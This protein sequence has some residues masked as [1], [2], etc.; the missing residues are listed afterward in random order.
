MVTA[1]YLDLLVPVTFD[2]SCSFLILIILYSWLLILFILHLLN[3][4]CHYN[5]HGLR[6]EVSGVISVLSHG[7]TPHLICSSVVSPHHHPACASVCWTMRCSESRSA[8]LEFLSAKTTLPDLRGE[9]ACNLE[10]CE[11]VWEAWEEVQE[12]L[13]DLAAVLHCEEY[14]PQ[15]WHISSNSFVSW[16][17]VPG[18]WW[19]VWWVWPAPRSPLRP[20]CPVEHCQCQHGGYHHDQAETTE[21]RRRSTEEQQSQL[22]LLLLLLAVVLWLLLADTL[23]LLDHLVKIIVAKNSVINQMFHLV[24]YCSWWRDEIHQRWT[25]PW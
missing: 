4:P 25:L 14:S 18:W 24:I 5:G 6:S 22:H 20:V 12:Y 16:P 3:N 19:S 21:Q 2:S 1:K 7:H 11:G 15:I 17:P 23:V 10:D 9:W 8:R 13:M